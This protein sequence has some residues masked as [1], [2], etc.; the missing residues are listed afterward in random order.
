MKKKHILNAFFYII[1]LIALTEII[2]RI[3]IIYE[4]IFSSYEVR[5]PPT[6]VYLNS[7]LTDKEVLYF[8]FNPYSKIEFSYPIYNLIEK[9]NQKNRNKDE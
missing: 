5:F 2:L 6:K 3:P 8:F 9:K 7:S 4:R 1:Y